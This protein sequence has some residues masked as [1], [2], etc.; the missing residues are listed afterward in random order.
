MSSIGFKITINI[1]NTSTEFLNVSLDLSLN[2]YRKPNSKTNYINNNFNHLKN[3][4]NN[5]PK[6]FKKD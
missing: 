3:I 4:R 1:D 5:I 2:T 6:A